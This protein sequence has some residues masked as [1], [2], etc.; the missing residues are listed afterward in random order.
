MKTARHK[1][2]NNVLLYRIGNYIQN[3]V[4]NY[5]GEE[6]AKE[7]IQIYNIYRKLNFAR[8]QKLIQHCKSTLTSIL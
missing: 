5:N 2:K 8:H 6:Y 7:F 1:I 4:I 3:L